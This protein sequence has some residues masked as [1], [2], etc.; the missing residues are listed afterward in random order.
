MAPGREKSG[1]VPQRR[2]S[3]V[4]PLAA[5]GPLTTPGGPQRGRSGARPWG[6]AGR[7]QGGACMPGRS[8]EVDE[9]SGQVAAAK[10]G[11]GRGGAWWERGVAGAGTLRKGQ[12]GRG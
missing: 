10:Q 9:G 5:P 11:G 6:G 8:W 2:S 3:E 4:G 1:A 12:L 7:R